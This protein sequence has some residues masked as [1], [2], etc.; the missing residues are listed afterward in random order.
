MRQQKLSQSDNMRYLSSAL[1]VAQAAPH[2]YSW[3]KGDDMTFDS[4]PVMYSSAINLAMGFVVTDE[5]EFNPLAMSAAMAL[6]LGITYSRFN[7]CND[8]SNS[9]WSV[10][11]ADDNQSTIEN[12]LATCSLFGGLI[13]MGQFDINREK[14]T[15]S[16][17]HTRSLIKY[18]VF[19]GYTDMTR[20]FARLGADL[21]T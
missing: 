9:N 10:F 13:G 14:S 17:T 19:G 2:F 5:C 6:P 16:G 3:F 4:M 20:A 12:V 8:L 21:S 11:S 1:R 15:T 18:Q 7:Y